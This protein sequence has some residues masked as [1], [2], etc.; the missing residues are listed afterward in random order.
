MRQNRAIEKCIQENEKN[1]NNLTIYGKYKLSICTKHIEI[2]FSTNKFKLR[3]VGTQVPSK[4]SS[5]NFWY[6][7]PPVSTAITSTESIELLMVTK[8]GMFII[9]KYTAP[10]FLPRQLVSV[11]VWL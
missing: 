1:S 9:P 5:C 2:K 7:S 3:L 6:S 4:S 11:N 8:E 10:P